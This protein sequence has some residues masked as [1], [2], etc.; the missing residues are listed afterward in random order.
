MVWN[1]FIIR[2]FGENHIILTSFIFTIIIYDGD[3]ELETEDIS[4]FMKFDRKNKIYSIMGFRF[5]HLRLIRSGVDWEN[6]IFT[7]FL[8]LI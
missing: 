7:P 8:S 4:K 5:K 2:F 3:L 6:F 1:I